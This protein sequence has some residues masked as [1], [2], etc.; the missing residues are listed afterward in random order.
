MA[1]DL[2]KNGVS[3]IT[4]KEGGHQNGYKELKLHCLASLQFIP[5]I[6]FPLLLVKKDVI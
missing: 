4:H 5:R 3:Q 6:I 2:F 1:A